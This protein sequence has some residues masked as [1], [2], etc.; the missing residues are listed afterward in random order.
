MHHRPEARR[1]AVVEQEP[2]AAVDGRDV[3]LLVDVA[4]GAR[5]VGPTIPSKDMVAERFHPAEHAVDFSDVPPSFVGVEGLQ[6]HPIAGSHA[7]RKVP[8]GHV[9]RERKGAS[10]ILL[11]QV[12]KHKRACEARE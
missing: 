7:G 6:E 9:H 1:Y 10:A 11:K 4:P 2:Q 12:D 5:Q 3:A 8:S